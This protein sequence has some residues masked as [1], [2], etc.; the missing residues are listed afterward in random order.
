MGV[1]F[2]VYIVDEKKLTSKVEEGEIKKKL[3]ENQFERRRIECNENSCNK[4][5]FIDMPITK[6]GTYYFKVEFKRTAAL[7]EWIRGFDFEA[8]TVNKEYNMIATLLKIFLFVLSLVLTC[9]YC[10]NL[11]K[12][13]QVRRAL[14]FEQKYLQYLNLGLVMFYD[15][16]GCAQIW[17]PSTFGLVWAGFW[18]ALFLSAFFFFWLVMFRRIV[19]ES[20]EEKETSKKIIWFLLFIVVVF[21]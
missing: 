15:P 19:Y 7:E 2:T 11:R 8:Y 21:D 9:L 17:Y 13:N 4:F 14:T 3:I 16:F 1:N 10:F 12:L 6:G 18:N 5:H 20:V